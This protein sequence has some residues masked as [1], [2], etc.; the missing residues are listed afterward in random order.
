MVEPAPKHRRTE[1]GRG[2]LCGNSD[3][4][5]FGRNHAAR[6][7]LST[8]NPAGKRSERSWR[9]DRAARWPATP[10]TAANV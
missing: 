5:C 4:G 2:P 9:C 7:P 3:A 1:D 6:Q 8:G 10:Y